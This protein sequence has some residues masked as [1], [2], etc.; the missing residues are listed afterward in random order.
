MDT[1][2]TPALERQT[3]NL[4][5]DVCVVGAGIAGLT[6]AYLLG[7]E[8]RKVI[9]L[10]GG[11][12]GAGESGRTTAHLTNALDDRYLEI[13]KVHGR[14]KSRRAADSHTQAIETIS[15]IVAAE[16]IDCDFD[17]VDGYLFLTADHAA[18]LLQQELAA[19]HR[20][21][22]ADVEL[23]PDGPDP[24]LPLGPC[25][26]FTRQGQ[27]HILKYLSGL[28]AAI[29]R[30]GGKIVTGA[31]VDSVK[32]KSHVHIG[33]KQGHRVTCRAAVMATNTPEIAPHVGPCFR[34]RVRG[35]PVSREPGGGDPAQFLLRA[36]RAPRPSP[37]CG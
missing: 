36:M 21:G 10:D 22:L 35:A 18:K 15:R 9:V 2:T 14:A 26:K 20:A 32:S 8:G 30:Q 16:E 28:A 19:A 3:R 31:R 27:F 23:L 6:T 7:R 12:I 5:A 11:S 29:E 1:S 33:T 34:A 4:E 13:E 37:R 17:R 24:K 25:L